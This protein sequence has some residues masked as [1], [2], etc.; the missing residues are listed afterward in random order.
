M[1]KEKILIVAVRKPEQHID[2]FQS[3]LDEL[4]SLSSTAGGTVETIVT[5]NR[6]HI[7]PATYIGKGKLEEIKEEIA[8]KEI[9]LVISNDELSSGQLRNLNNY[10]GIRIIDRSQLILDIFAT[11]AQTKEGHLQVELAQLEYLLPRLRGQG[12]ELSRLGAGIGTRGP[13]ETKLET[14]QRHIRSRIVDIKRRLELVVKQ[15]EQYRKRR[16]DNDVFQIAIV[17]YTNAGKST[18]FNQLTDSKSLEEDKLFATLDPLTRKVQLPAGFEALVTDTVGFIQDLPTSLIASFRST[19]EEVTEADFLIHV[20][21]GS[22][23]DQVQHQETVVKLLEDLDAANLPTL[24]VYNKKDLLN[25]DF[26]PLNHPFILVSAYE[27]TDVQKTLEKIEKI[28]MEEWIPYAKELEP[29]QGKIISQL[30]RESIIIEKS[31][32]EQNN[33]Y[34]IKGY[35]PEDHTL[36][37]LI[38]E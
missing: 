26:F 2:R 19:L 32:D 34:F 10:L 31:F 7:H 27:E 11:R 38:K 22:H 30:E 25:D 17:G 4:I 8:E 15:R 18:L 28:L 37:R 35:I 36:N 6:S 29:N 9:E 13:G 20:V 5:Q 12:V 3:S 21:D 14:D 16:R 1:A 23:I 24:Y 33:F